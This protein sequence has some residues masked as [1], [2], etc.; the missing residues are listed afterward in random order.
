V[1]IAAVV[2]AAGH[3][4]RLRPLTEL[5]PKALCPVDNEP[6]LDRALRHVRSV[7]ADVAVNAHS[8]AQQ[9]VDHL[10]GDDR[11]HVSVEHAEA[12]GTAGAL[13]NLRD[14]VDGR[15]VLV[16]N[17]DGWHDADI[18]VRVVDGWDG[19]TMRLMVVERP[20]AADFGRYL[21]AGVCL[22]PWRFV[23]GL[24]PEPSGIYELLW[25]DAVDQ[26]DFAV[27]DGAFFDCGTPATYLA[28][29]LHASGGVSVIAPDA[30]VH[31][32]AE[33]L[34]SVVWPHATVEAGERLVECI[35]AP[36]G[37]TVDASGGA[38]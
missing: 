29:N 22:L 19:E 1:E 33:I 25:R 13:G 16:H 32:G 26:L 28:A 20:H 14:W 6:L 38:A 15:A 4:T 10:A 31:E 11:V 37:L 23:K 5:V 34:R 18:A 36:G 12:L 27:H 3:G 9:I 35:R 2:L 30:T 21:Y 8:L 24:E 17:A 7:T